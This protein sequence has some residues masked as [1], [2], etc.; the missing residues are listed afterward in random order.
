MNG[1]A[2]VISVLLSHLSYSK[3][4]FC[5]FFNL[6]SDFFEESFS[7]HKT[8]RASDIIIKKYQTL[9]EQNI[10]ENLSMKTYNGLSSERYSSSM[11][12]LKTKEGLTHYL[13]RND[14][15]ILE[16]QDDASKIHPCQNGLITPIV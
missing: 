11:K 2:F 13:P 15:V 10:S 12:K 8:G 3:K 1:D 7:A 9:L 14:V 16:V 5:I 4:G 6:I